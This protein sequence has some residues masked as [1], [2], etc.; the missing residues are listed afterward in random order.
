VLFVS[1]LLSH[2]LASRAG[3][4]RI[5]HRSVVELGAG[6]G[7]PGVVAAHFASKV[8]VTD[9]NEIVLDLLNQ[10]VTALQNKRDSNVCSVSALQLVW[11]NHGHIQALLENM[12]AVDV[13][14]AADVVQWPSVLEPLLRT[15]KALLW[16]S[17][18]KQPVFIVGIVNR[19]ASTY[20]MVFDLAGDFGFTY[21]KVEA[22]EY[23][24]DGVV[25]KSC[26]EFGGRET[27]IYQFIL[28]DRS[29]Y[30]VLLPKKPDDTRDWT[31]GKSYE[32]TGFLPC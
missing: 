23:L 22:E 4:A 26:Q 17:E 2:Y 12:S 3:Q 13:V 19:A 14:V 31:V 32:N 25:P 21:R 18:E 24:P 7:L 11:G 20:D 15:V 29:V 30:P 6:T 28:K 5:Q 10:N 1:V 8:A 27:E 9:G 16:N